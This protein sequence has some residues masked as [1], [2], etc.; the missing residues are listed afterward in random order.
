MLRETIKS[1]ENLRSRILEHRENCEHWKN[2]G[3]C[4]D[5]HNNKIGKIEK[6]LN[7]KFI[8]LINYNG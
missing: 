1:W 3:E 5:C 6:E 4:H 8:E 2:G 7:K